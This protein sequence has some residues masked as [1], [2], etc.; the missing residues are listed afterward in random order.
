MNDTRICLAVAQ[1]ALSH[2]A[3][4]ANHVEVQRLLKDPV[5]GRVC[6][7]HVRDQ[8]SGREWDICAQSV[9]NAT[10]PFSD[11]IR[12]MDDAQARDIIA[13]SAGVHIM[14]SD[15]CTSLDSADLIL[16]CSLLMLNGVCH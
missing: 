11:S 3:R 10:G 13:P 6:G 9:I 2:G 15:R 5:T 14:L 7:A 16:H 12:K 8:V 4:C 1:T